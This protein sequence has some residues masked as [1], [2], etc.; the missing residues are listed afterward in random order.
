M[1][2]IDFNAPDL[3]RQLEQLSDAERD[4]APF[5]I[6]KLDGSGRVTEFNATEARLS[7]YGSRPALGLDFFASV[8]PCMGTPEFKGRIEQAQRLGA[9]DIEIGHVGD[10]SDPD[11][12]LQLRAQSASDGGLWICILREAMF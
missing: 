5:G 10:F 11:R 9:V 6:I 2:L 3:A 1:T 7:G 8:A 12:E 4:A